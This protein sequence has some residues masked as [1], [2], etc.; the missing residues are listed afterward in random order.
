[1]SKID[2]CKKRIAIVEAAA[3]RCGCT[4]MEIYAR[5]QKNL[6]KVVL[7]LE[8]I[9]ERVIR[10]ARRVLRQPLAERMAKRPRQQHFRTAPHMRAC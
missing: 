3:A 5:A 9:P 1:M 8:K 6:R 7:N 4:I 2:R 10:Y